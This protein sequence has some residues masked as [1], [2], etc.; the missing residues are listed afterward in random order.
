MKTTKT[1]FVFNR[2]RLY[3][4]IYNLFITFT[5]QSKKNSINYRTKR[6]KSLNKIEKIIHSNL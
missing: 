1:Y 2:E 3:T 4:K 6:E 5:R